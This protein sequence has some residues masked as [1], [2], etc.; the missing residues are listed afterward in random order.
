MF[1]QLKHVC[2]YN[3]KGKKYKIFKGNSHEIEFI[4]NI[5]IL[6]PGIP[7]F[8]IIKYEFQENTIWIRERRILDQSY[9]SKQWTEDKHKFIKN[10]EDTEFKFLKDTWTNQWIE[11]SIPT[12]IEVKIKLKD[13][14][15]NFIVPFIINKS[16]QL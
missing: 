12:A 6:S 11:H 7:G 8:Y 5:S 1:N 4:S 16:I 3:Y 9:I 14:L 10:V 13:K 15:I 2:S